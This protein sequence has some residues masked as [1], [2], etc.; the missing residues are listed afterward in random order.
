MGD[1]NSFR[2]MST[3]NEKRHDKAFDSSQLAKIIRIFSA[4][5]DKV[6]TVESVGLSLSI[7]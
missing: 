7:P 6:Y 2:S 4:R 1:F 3:Q 5:P